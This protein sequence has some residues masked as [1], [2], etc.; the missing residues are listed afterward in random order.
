MKH[1]MAD[2][3]THTHTDTHTTPIDTDITLSGL[4]RSDTV[5]WPG[6]RVHLAKLQL[7]LSYQKG[8]LSLLLTRLIIVHKKAASRDDTLLHNLNYVGCV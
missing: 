4:V 1:E 5:R 2:Y 6:C 8:H 7:G 3:N